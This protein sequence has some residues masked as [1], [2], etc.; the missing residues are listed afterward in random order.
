MVTHSS[1]LTAVAR[2]SPASPEVDRG[3]EQALTLLLP[4]VTGMTIT[5]A[6][7]A[8]LEDLAEAQPDRV[9]FLKR[10]VVRRL[11]REGDQVVGCEY[12]YQ[13]EKQTAHGPVI[14]ATG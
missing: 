9:K 13:G 11:V 4:F 5:Y 6:L 8:K 2:S 14:L 7:M 12:E 1:A 10:A 3:D